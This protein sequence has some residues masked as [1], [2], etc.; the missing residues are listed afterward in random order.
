[1]RVSSDV[2]RRN[3][4]CTLLNT[5]KFP[6]SI[7][8]IF[9]I[10]VAYFCIVSFVSCHNDVKEPGREK[11]NRI[12]LIGMDGLEWRIV[13]ELIEKDQLPNIKRLI[14][15]GTRARLR[16]IPPYLSPQIWTSIVT[17]RPPEEHGITWFMVRD[18]ETGQTR[19]VTSQNRRVKALWNIASEAGK[20]VG[21][22]GWWASWPAEKVN[23]FIVT[24]RIGHHG[25]SLGGVEDE[26]LDALTYP[27]ALLGKINPFITKPKSLSRSDIQPFF[28]IPQSEFD[29]QIQLPFT[30]ENKFHHFTY[31][32]ANFQTHE[33]VGLKLGQ[34]KDLDL[35]GVYLEAVDTTSHLFMKFR[36]PKME[37][38]DDD[39]FGR[40]KGVVD[41]I[42]RANDRALGR[43]LES[44]GP[45]TTVILCSD[46]G[47]KSGDDR[48]KEKDVTSIKVAHKWHNPEG[49]LVMRGPMMKKNHTL[50]SASVM[51]ITP[52]ILHILGLPVADDF[53][54]EVLLES[55]KPEWRA[56]HPVTTI[57]TYEVEGRD[58]AASPAN[59]AADKA[60]MERLL[61]LGY[62]S[63]GKPAEAPR[64]EAAMSI[65]MHF[66]EI[67]LL[68]A[69]GKLDDALTR[70]RKTVEYD[71]RHPNAWVLLAEC[72]LLTRRVEEAEMVLDRAEDLL[73]II[74]E[75][76]P[77]FPNGKPRYSP[78]DDISLSRI[79]ATRGGIH[80]HR[81]NLKE[82]ETLLR[83]AHGLDAHNVTACYRLALLYEQTKRSE[84]AGK[85]YHRCL[86]DQSD[87][88]PSLN[89][90]ANIYLHEQKIDEARAL[91]QKAAQANPHHAESRYNLGLIALNRGDDENS[92]QYFKQV[93]D[94]D[95]DYL[96]A[97][98]QLAGIALKQHDLDAAGK[99]LERCVRLAPGD[100]PPLLRLTEVKARQQKISEAKALLLK[101]RELDEK[102]AADVEKNYP[103][104]K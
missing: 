102:S 72:L 104:V 99:Y 60:M 43:F 96:P 77:L 25:F 79:Q 52:T 65:E 34:D 1:M 8:I 101:L 78:P 40:F 69:K 66:N 87:H 100:I 30:F 3:S 9:G 18:P 23:G 2:M 19:S 17:G 20:R 53:E 58:K 31:M 22:V 42:Y 91:Y 44:A 51:D 64:A 98:S 33:R 49:V 80:M 81:G 55:F 4:G 15:E 38:V 56:K 41:E 83:K 5:M 50:A 46:H 14:E 21:F 24:D 70:A 54:G 12:F 94:I 7:G 68:I 35:F 26:N 89:N 47:F 63:K 32:L 36:P 48:L 29:K 86:E 82:A 13:D 84:L 74:A 28:P 71:P 90:L 59:P 103:A 61:S 11:R 62:L 92:T 88:A 27:D 16:S 6:R 67:A 85:T 39:L 73:E 57:P 75:N 37:T 45:E 95:S 10:I 97:L 93:I 76:P